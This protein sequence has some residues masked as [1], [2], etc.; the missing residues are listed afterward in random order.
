MSDYEDNE[1]EEDFDD[2]DDRDE[3]EPCGYCEGAGSVTG[4]LGDHHG[5]CGYC[6]GLGMMPRQSN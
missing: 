3:F 1:F 5:T 4:L 6:Y 2:D